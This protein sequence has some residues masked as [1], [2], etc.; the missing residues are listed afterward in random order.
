MSRCIIIGAVFYGVKEV[1][2][3]YSKLLADE[4][5]AKFATGREIVVFTHGHHGWSGTYS[6]TGNTG[7]RA[8]RTTMA[9]GKIF[10]KLREVQ[11][12]ASVAD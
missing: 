12:R 9:S 11:P 1:T 10:S 8:T 2:M 3:R 4:S 7:T 5:V 6:C